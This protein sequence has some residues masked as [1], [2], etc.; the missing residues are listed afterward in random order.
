MRALH[1][2]GGKA[3]VA[4]GAGLAG[5]RLVPRNSFNEVVT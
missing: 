2:L 1:G 5:Q 3:V 4:G